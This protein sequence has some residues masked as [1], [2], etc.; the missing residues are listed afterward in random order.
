MATVKIHS[1]ICGFCTMV[2]ATSENTKDVSLSII[3]ECPGYKDLGN[4]LQHVDAFEECFA[5]VGEGKVYETCRKYCKHSA[6]P[7]PSGIIKAIEVSC[8]LALPHDVT[9]EVSK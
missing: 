6:C 1:G 3:S 5:K 8:N 2:T 7:V 9:I 4:D